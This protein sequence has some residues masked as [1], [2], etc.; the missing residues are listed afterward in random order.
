MVGI[1]KGGRGVALIL[2]LA[3]AALHAQTPL[4]LE[5]AASRNPAA[6]YLPR[7]VDR[8]VRL[9]GVVN[10]PAF[11][12]PDQTLLAIEDGHYGAILRV[13]GADARLN[14]FTPGDEV[15]AEGII[16]AI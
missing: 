12:F 5:E 11:H 7:H 14:S 8:Q 9:R 15:E 3:A 6:D 13:E 2:A 10:C 16:H 1:R 4:S